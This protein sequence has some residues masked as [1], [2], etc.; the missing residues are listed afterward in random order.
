MEHFRRLT[1]FSQDS[2]PLVLSALLSFTADKP[3]LPTILLTGEYRNTRKSEEHSIFAC[4][5]PRQPD[6]LKGFHPMRQATI[7]PQD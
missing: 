1:S 6:V 4:C 7:K 2:L 5:L 3:H